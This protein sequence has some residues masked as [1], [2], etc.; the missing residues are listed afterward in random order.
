[1]PY[2]DKEENFYDY[3][4]KAFDG[5]NPFDTSK[6]GISFYNQFLTDPAYMEDYKNLK[7]N[8][9]MMTPEE[10][11]E[12]CAHI[13]NSSKQKQIDQT[14]WDKNILSHLKEVLIKYKKTFPITFLNYAEESQEGRHRMYVVG[15]LLGWDKKFPVMIINW[16][17][18]KKQEEKE[19]SQKQNERDEIISNID[20]IANDLSSIEYDN[21]DEV[22]EDFEYYLRFKYYKNDIKINYINNSIEFNVKGVEYKVPVWKFDINSPTQQ[23]NLDDYSQEEIE[24]EL[25]RMGLKNW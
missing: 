21:I 13:F 25:K 4:T 22:I 20:K 5:V 1:M 17:D 24:A 6:T 7:H 16:A 12:E 18:P 9:V 8:I 11:F 14:G 23:S 10:Y 15:E 3:G 2:L 19:I